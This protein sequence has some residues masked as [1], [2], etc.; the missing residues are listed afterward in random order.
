[1]DVSNSLCGLHLN[2]KANT[3]LKPSFGSWK[4][5][6]AL[7]YYELAEYILIFQQKQIKQESPP[8]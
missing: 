5:Y 6:I 7:P 2:F 3:Q 8:A 1:M 4:I